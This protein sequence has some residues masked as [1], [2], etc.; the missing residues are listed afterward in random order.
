MRFGSGQRATAEGVVFRLGRHRG[1]PPSGHSFQERLALWCGLC[2][3]HHAVHGGA[4]GLRQGLLSGRAHLRAEHL[5]SVTHVEPRCDGVSYPAGPRIAGKIGPISKRLVLLLDQARLLRSVG[6]HGLGLTTALRCHCRIAHFNVPPEQRG[7]PVDWQVIVIVAISAASFVAFFA[8]G[9][10]PSRTS[11]STHSKASKTAP[12]RQ[13]QPV[14][15]E[16]AS[17]FE[18]AM[19]S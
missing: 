18:A 8:L 9:E 14:D 1:S 5:L 12:R 11:K 19:K 6:F 17:R 13:A 16:I 7:L 15:P 3:R 2:L 4:I 10:G